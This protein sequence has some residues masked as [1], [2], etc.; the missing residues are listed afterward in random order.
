MTPRR[1]RSTVGALCLTACLALCG[2]GAA[3]TPL[4]VR[5]ALT[6]QSRVEQP[7]W[8]LEP[9]T[10]P[11][12]L[13]AAAASGNLAFSWPWNHEWFHA[14]EAVL[15]AI[16]TGKKEFAPG[17]MPAYPTLDPALRAAAEARGQGRS[18]PARYISGNA[19]GTQPL[20][21]ADLVVSGTR[22]QLLAA[23][24]SQ[25]WVT[26]QP[27][28]AWNLFKLGV[29]VLTRLWNDEAAPVSELYLNGRIED[30]ALE[31]DSD[32][33]LSRDH[34]RA[35]ALDATGTRWAIAAS[36]DIAVTVAFKHPSFSG[37]KVWKIHWPTPDLSHAA[38][39]H[40]DAER[41]LV[42][43]DLLKSGRLKAWDAVP[44][45]PSALTTPSP[46]TTDGESYELTLD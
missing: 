5:G 17:T 13:D 41:D 1:A 14:W 7:R 40:C 10:L 21:P 28:T 15:S 32:Y 20:E 2:C 19:A 34:L 6:A 3:P 35:Y 44:T 37:W 30:F 18:E 43:L 46:Y 33:V 29:S 42:L 36:R 45:M 22:E 12:E 31:K 8:Q 11:P 38:D 24:E 39:L 4:A 23:F 9:T 27:H 25:G 16:V 26:V